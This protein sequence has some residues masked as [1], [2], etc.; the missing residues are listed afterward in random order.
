[1]ARGDVAAD[2]SIESAEIRSAL[3]AALDAFVRGIEAAAA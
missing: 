1:V 3:R 2:G